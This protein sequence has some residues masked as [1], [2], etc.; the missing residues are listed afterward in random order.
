MQVK[1]AALAKQAELNK[2]NTE[3]QA[4]CSSMKPTTAQAPAAQQ[5]A[6]AAPKPEAAGPAK[7]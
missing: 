6:S 5:T 4:K 2:L 1:R 7:Q 3:F